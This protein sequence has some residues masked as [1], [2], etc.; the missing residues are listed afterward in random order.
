MF[1]PPLILDRKIWALATKYAKE[2]KSLDLKKDVTF[3]S[4]FGGSS[5]ESV[6]CRCKMISA[7][8]GKTVTSAKILSPQLLPLRY[9]AKYPVLDLRCRLEDG[10]EVDVEI[11][12][13]Y[14]KDEF[15]KRS[16]Y[17]ASR[18]VAENLDSGR[19]YENLSHVYQIT[20]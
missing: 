19:K 8:I 9:K 13:K 5:K 16:V 14:Y 4:F 6:Y 20:N 11:Q 17:Y 2:G 12:G 7:V 15:V 3:K 18:L 10:S 1:T